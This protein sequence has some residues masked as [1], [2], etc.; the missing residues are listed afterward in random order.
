[1]VTNGNKKFMSK[2]LFMS[3][4]EGTTVT[5]RRETRL[6]RKI[7]SCGS[8][9]DQVLYDS[10]FDFI[11]IFKCVSLHVMEDESAEHENCPLAQYIHHQL[12]G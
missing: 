9:K 2:M 3:V 7:K 1:M 8:E 11:V 10:S 5:A 4:R 12:K 6:V